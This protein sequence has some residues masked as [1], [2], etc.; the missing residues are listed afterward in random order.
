MEIDDSINILKNIDDI[1][2]DLIEDTIT[3]NKINLNVG[4]KKILIDPNVLLK[5]N[6]SVNKLIKLDD[7]TLFL[8]RDYRFF[9]Q[10]INFGKQYGLN[11]E[12]IIDNI[13][14]INTNIRIELAFYNL[15]DKKY[16]P[17]SILNIPKNILNTNRNNDIITINI[18]NTIF[19]TKYSTLAKSKFF[20]NKLMSKNKSI[21]L[22]DLSIDPKVF[23]FVLNSF[24]HG[25]LFYTNDDIISTIQAF[26]FD[27]DANIISSSTCPDQNIKYGTL[28]TH[29]TTDA[30]NYQQLYLLQNAPIGSE[31]MLSTTSIMNAENK[32]GFDSEI[33]FDLTPKNDSS[34]EYLSDIVIIVD[35][36]VLNKSS[37]SKY[38]DNL[39]NKIIEYIQLILLDGTISTTVGKIYIQQLSNTNKITQPH[40]I[41]AIYSDRM[42]EVYRVNIP[43]KLRSDIPI[44]RIKISGKKLLVKVKIA[45]MI[46][47]IVNK[48]SDIILLNC[49]LLNSYK[50]YSPLGLDEAGNTIKINKNI[51]YNTRNI[52]FDN[53]EN[54]LINSSSNIIGVKKFSESNYDVYSIQLTS[55]RM[56]NEIFIIMEQDNLIELEF[57][58]IGDNNT[59]MSM[60]K[61]DSMF[62]TEYLPKKI[63]GEVL[64]PGNYYYANIYPSTN[65]DYITPA[66]SEPLFIIIKTVKTNNFINMFI[67]YCFSLKM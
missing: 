64:S 47:I 37:E 67:N 10:I 50:N 29:V 23:R 2:G 31:H 60:G 46:D 8:D 61:F 66:L 63:F 62:M 59:I 18:A 6:I 58:T 26:G 22:S 20:I 5:L 13:D 9:L 16:I 33:I 51:K 32:I 53:W 11:R 7:N 28:H 54:I 41:K 24:R 49:Y 48:K 34:G 3:N 56:I 65:I 1:L 14:I 17:N 42:I 35:L 12:S 52:I 27:I 45:S 44:N 30:I 36:P 55:K 57:V 25:N 43:I 4:G 39:Q 21:D 19:M 15:L 38:I 40:A